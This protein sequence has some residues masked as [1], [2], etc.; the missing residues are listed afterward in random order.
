MIKSNHHGADAIGSISI[1]SIKKETREKENGTETW[2]SSDC[3]ESFFLG[4]S[5]SLWSKN[6]IKIKITKLMSTLSSFYFYKINGII[7]LL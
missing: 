1:I 6:N 3:I 2:L 5:F 7:F 4:R